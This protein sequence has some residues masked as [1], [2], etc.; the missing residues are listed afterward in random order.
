MAFPCH[1]VQQQHLFG[2]P[3]GGAACLARARAS[4]STVV[5][6]CYACRDCNLERGNLKT[7]LASRPWL[8]YSESHICEPRH[9]ATVLANSCTNFHRGLSG[10]KR[11]ASFSV[12]FSWRRVNRGSR[13]GC[14]RPQNLHPASAKLGMMGNW[15]I[16][17]SKAVALIPHINWSP[18]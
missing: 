10:R 3:R 13:N 16:V 2:H 18:T 11:G 17:R 7:S 15:P 1:T 8:N 12:C 4:A 9:R 5:P 6:H 14:G